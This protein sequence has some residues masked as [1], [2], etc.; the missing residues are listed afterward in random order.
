[1]PDK[2]VVAES[3]LREALY[4][5]YESHNMLP[6]YK[7]VYAN[8]CPNKNLNHRELVDLAEMI[9]NQ[10]LAQNDGDTKMLLQPLLTI[11]KVIILNDDIDKYLAPLAKDIDVNKKQFS[12]EDMKNAM[13]YGKY[14]L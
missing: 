10:S 7:A 11:S 4:N 3:N 6:P 9:F 14:Q 12:L 1:M 13:L 8:R 5:H 2:A